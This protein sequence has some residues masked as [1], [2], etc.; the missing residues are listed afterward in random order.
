[1]FGFDKKPK[2]GGCIRSPDDP[3][4]F[5]ML[6]GARDDDW[7]KF[8]DMRILCSPVED[9]R[10][11][12]SCTA[13][14]CVGA[15]EILERKNEPFH[16]DLSRLFVYY[17]T[18]VIDDSV[19]KDQGAYLS[20]S[21]K[22]LKQYGACLESTWP[23]NPKHILQK[24]DAECYEEAF[25]TKVVEYA[26]VAQ[27]G[28]IRAALADGYPV[29]FGMMLEESFMR[30]GKDGIVALPGQLPEWVGGH[31][32]LIVGYDEVRELY[33]V[34]NSWGRK[35]GLDGYCLIPFRMVDNPQMSWDFWVIKGVEDPSDNHRIL[36][37]PSEG[38]A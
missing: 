4:D 8:V 25:L 26:R 17:N 15:L 19:D 16:S 22:A 36:R 34:R 7:P 33:L 10:A 6:C 24:P 28:P 2:V 20:S 1:M 37:G 31:A 12:N 27:G 3:R 11:T 30:T 35:W 21:M 5:I 9:Q 14:A 18:R 32:M 29:V 38:W 13:N 23:F